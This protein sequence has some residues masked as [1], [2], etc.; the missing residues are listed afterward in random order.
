MI[1]SSKT[2]KH[3]VF[4]QGDLRIEARIDHKK[5]GDRYFDRCSVFCWLYP[6]DGANVFAQRINA[7]DRAW[8]DQAVEVIHAALE[9]LRDPSATTVGLSFSAKCGCSCP[10]SPG[11]LVKQAVDR[12]G[13]K[14]TPADLWATNVYINAWHMP[15][16]ASR[17]ADGLRNI[18]SWPVSETTIDD[19]ATPFCAVG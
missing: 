12:Y 10:C 11:F 16:V 2:I 18:M 17:V 7:S 14:S 13:S 6:A 19:E 9:A 3:V 1:K 4:D 5:R 15:T 8:K